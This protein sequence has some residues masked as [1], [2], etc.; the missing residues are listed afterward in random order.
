MVQ[1]LHFTKE[2][3]LNNT[4]KT[5]NSATILAHKEYHAL[6]SEYSLLDRPKYT[7]TASFYAVR[8]A[9]S[10]TKRSGATLATGNTCILKRTSHL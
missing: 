5:E 3:N 6:D 8:M 2:V 4:S 1:N 10:Y 9:K 7:S